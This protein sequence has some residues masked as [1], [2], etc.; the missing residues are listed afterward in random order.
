MQY[1]LKLNSNNSFHTIT[2]SGKTIKEKNKN[3]RT[4]SNRLSLKHLLTCFRQLKTIF[5][6]QVITPRYDGMILSTYVQVNI[7]YHLWSPIFKSHL[8]D[9]KWYL[10]PWANT[11][12][13]SSINESKMSLDVALVSSQ[14]AITCSKL[15]IETLEQDVEYVQS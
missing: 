1:N 14:L 5:K 10:S 11:C 2:T 12:L 7:L 9:S 4:L 13:T 15:T 3:G 6:T 8:N